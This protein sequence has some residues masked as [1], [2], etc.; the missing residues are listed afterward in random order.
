M[1]HTEFEQFIRWEF[2]LPE[3]ITDKNY[4]QDEGQDR[5]IAEDQKQSPFSIFRLF[6]KYINK[7]YRVEDEP[8]RPSDINQRSE[9][10]PSS[11][12]TPLPLRMISSSEGKIKKV[13]VAIPS[14]EFK[15]QKIFFDN[16]ERLLEILHDTTFYVFTHVD[17]PFDQSKDFEERYKNLAETERKNIRAQQDKFREIIKNAS[18]ESGREIHL[19]R[20]ELGFDSFSY[21]IQDPFLITQLKIKELSKF[22]LVQ[23]HLFHRGQDRHIAED[24]DDN[25]CGLLRVDLRKTDLYFEGGNILV[26]DDFILI[27]RDY[28]EL[29]KYYLKL[30]DH[31]R[32]SGEEQ[33]EEIRDRFRQKIDATRELIIIGNTEP[34]DPGNDYEFN[35]ID[36][37]KHFFYRGWGKWQPLVHLDLFITL[38]GRRYPNGPYRILVGDLYNAS[39]HHSEDFDQAY[40]QPLKDR[41]DE[42]AF[43]LKQL[44]SPDGKSRFE[45]YRMPLP[46]TYILVQNIGLKT[47]AYKWYPLSYNNCLI[48]NDEVNVTAYYPTFNYEKKN[49]PT[50]INGI[51]GYIDTTKLADFDDLVYK[52]W[53]ALGVKPHPLKDYLGLM[54]MGGGVHCIVKYIEREDFND[55]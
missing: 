1:S 38:L 15:S 29:S 17:D 4:R 42:I 50:K 6:E 12:P 44:K 34:F 53:E 28:V 5:S 33:D 49:K 37:A 27:G 47:T 31:N 23:P 39:D 2:N 25:I 16:L 3:T 18:N 13:L 30:K 19:V 35:K 51:E 26:G 52:T 20:P 54:L 11:V 32:F 41:L 40:F 43:H 36:D 9:L 55:V 7:V 10:P 45:V 8:V 22:F 48:E 46:V 24:I 14:H 21:W